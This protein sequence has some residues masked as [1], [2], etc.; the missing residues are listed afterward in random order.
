MIG[1]LII[2]TGV[3]G[4]VRERRGSVRGEGR[5]R[6]KFVGKIFEHVDEVGEG[7]VWG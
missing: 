1:V 2:H 3:G 7:V 6:I 4:G 5:D